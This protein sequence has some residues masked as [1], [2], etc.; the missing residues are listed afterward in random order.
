M[1][2]PQIYIDTLNSRIADKKAGRIAEANAKKLVLNTTFGV[3]LNGKG[4]E[5][6]NDLYDPLMGRSICITGQLLLIELSVH[7]IKECPTLKIIQLNTDGI[8][9]SLDKED[10]AKWQEITREWQDRTGFELEEDLIQKIVQRDVNNYIEIPMGGGKP[11]L[12]GGVLVRG[13]LTNANLDFTQYGLRQWENMTGGAWKV[14]ND[15]VIIAH[16]VRDYFVNGADPEETI[17]NSTEILDFQLISKAG[18]KYESCYQIVGDDEIPMQKVNRVY[19]VDDYNAGTLYKVHAKTKKS[20][21]IPGLPMHCIVDNENRLDLSVIDK[22]W[23]V[24][25][26]KRHI[27]EFLGKKGPKRNTRRVNALKKEALKILGG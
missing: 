22:D 6:Y 26:A 15:A 9:V 25:E 24:R 20:A 23:Y 1:P 17:Y 21:K 16:A 3:M 2:S 10:E 13:I 4:D 5:A 27:R 11:K 12:K 8:M 18:G 14:N 7:L 19:A